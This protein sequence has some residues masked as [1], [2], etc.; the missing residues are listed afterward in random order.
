MFWIILIFIILCIFTSFKIAAIIYAVLF[1]IL[2]IQGYF[3]KKKKDEEEEQKR[4]NYENERVNIAL[5]KEQQRT[6]YEQFIN[7]YKKYYGQTDKEIRSA[8]YYITSTVL[9]FSQPRKIILGG[10]DLSFDDILSSKILHEK[11]RDGYG[12]SE[13]NYTVLVNVN[14]L[15]EPI[16]KIDVDDDKDKAQ[17]INALLKV[18]IHN[19]KKD[20]APTRQTDSLQIDHD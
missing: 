19:N 11:I 9:V 12:Y 2:A 8:D 17:E 16:I 3:L 6:S 10:S 7:T 13:H 18:I 15:S 14:S 20:S 4:I 5:A 1:V